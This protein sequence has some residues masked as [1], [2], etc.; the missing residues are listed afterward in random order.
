LQQSHIFPEWLYDDIYDDRHSYRVQST[1]QD[2]HSPRPR[3]GLYERLLCPKCDQ[4]RLAQPSQI[5]RVFG[6]RRA[7]RWGKSLRSQ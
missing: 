7:S 1:A 2:A 5:Q 4:G 6:Q 3:K